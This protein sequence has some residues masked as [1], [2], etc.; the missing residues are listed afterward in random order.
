[1]NVFGDFVERWIMVRVFWRMVGLVTFELCKVQILFCD[2]VTKCSFSTWSGVWESDVRGME[3]VFKC[4]VGI[5][6]VS[7]Q[8]YVC[9]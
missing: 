2:E 5:I 8:S 1:M 9:K 7:S 3:C 6:S 4:V